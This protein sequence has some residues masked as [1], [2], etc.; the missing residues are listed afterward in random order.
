MNDREKKRNVSDREGRVTLKL[1]Y[2]Y[3]TGQY[4]A[5]IYTTGLLDMEHNA[6]RHKTPG[7]PEWLRTV[8]QW[9]Y[10]ILSLGALNEMRWCGVS[11]SSLYKMPF[12]D[13]STYNFPYFFYFVNLTTVHCKAVGWCF[14]EKKKSAVSILEESFNIFILYIF[15]FFLFFHWISKLLECSQ[16]SHV[17]ATFDNHPGCSIWRCVYNMLSDKYIY[18]WD[19]WH[20]HIVYIG[21]ICFV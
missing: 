5:T 11:S 13:T 21:Y 20:L 16:A 6:G 7:E 2:M 8:Q 12:F 19:E 17:A 10:I 9:Q 18:M 14:K 15:T 3:N 4:I 1:S